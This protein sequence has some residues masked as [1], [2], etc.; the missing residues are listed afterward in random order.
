MIE[1][2]EVRSGFDVE[3]LLGA[4]YIRYLLLSSVDTGDFPTRVQMALGG[5]TLSLTIHPPPKVRR[6]YAPLPAK[7]PTP[8]AGSFDVEIVF[9]DPHGADIALSLVCDISILLGPAATPVDYPQVGLTLFIAFGMSETLD[10]RGEV[11][12]AALTIDVRHVLAS[13][14]NVNIMLTGA[15]PLALSTLNGIVGGLVSPDLFGDGAQI[16]AARSAKHR[17]GNRTE[18]A[19][20]IY[21]NFWLRDGVADDDF[22]PARGD[23][24]EAVNFLPAGDDLAMAMAGSVYAA[25]AAD[26]L[27]RLAQPVFEGHEPS[28]GYYHPIRTLDA[29]GKPK[30]MAIVRSID[31]GAARARYVK[32]DGSKSRKLDALEITIRGEYTA[33]GAYQP[34]FTLRVHLI[35]V[36]SKGLLEWRTEYDLDLNLLAEAIPF[37]FFFSLLFLFGPAA[38]ALLA[39]QWVA[40]SLAGQEYI[41]ED[42][43]LDQI[44][45]TVAAQTDQAVGLLDAVPHRVAVVSKRWDPF[46]ATDHQVLTV[47]EDFAL[48]DDGIRLHG[49]AWLDRQPRPVEHA[50]VR[51]EERNE[52]LAITGL[53]YR[54]KDHRSYTDLFEVLFPA[55]DRREFVQVDEEDEPKNVY[56]L[57][58]DEV[59]ARLGSDRLRRSVPYLP[60][61]VHLVRNQV[62]RILSI[63]Q[64]ERD[65]QE[66]DLIN[67]HRDFLRDREKKRD[68]DAYHADA[69]AQ[70]AAELGGKPTPQEIEARI[71]RLIDEATQD[72]LDRYVDQRV[73]ALLQAAL[74]ALAQLDLAPHEYGVLQDERV[75]L[76]R[77]FDRINRQGRYYYRDRADRSLKDNLMSLPKYPSV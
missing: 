74:E 31:I 51:D 7:L 76:V 22:K 5:P 75:L 33:S 19:I 14:P 55:T 59:I 68:F 42:L 11:T 41:A 58:M 24:A 77:G 20:G 10:A 46:Y 44:A 6:R 2:S 36:V 32:S 9:D 29:D 63:S 16:Q 28:G 38:G 50:V 71:D 40:L 66:A 1:A 62:R 18:P 53:R 26:A 60:L 56:R 48:D 8:L 17:G 34:N 69:V 45:G 12:G 73:P 54:I 52:D 70:L 39:G 47:L 13:H 49:K 72:E 64:T 3:V 30:D 27:N 25:L 37:M 57:E 21:I 61:K 43:A 65:E 23:T 4:D 35:P 15:M 67:K